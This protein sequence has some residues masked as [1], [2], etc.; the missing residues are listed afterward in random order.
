VTSTTANPHVFDVGQDNFETDVLQASLD[1]PVLIDF[2]AEWCGPCKTL[3]PMLEKLT[4]E[5]N[6][7]FLR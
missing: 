2:W 1:T 5:Y 3:G 7:A 6:G 4:A